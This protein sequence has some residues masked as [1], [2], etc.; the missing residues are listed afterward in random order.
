MISP[1]AAILLPLAPTPLQDTYPTTPPALELSAAAV[2]TSPQDGELFPW[3]EPGSQWAPIEIHTLIR[4]RA[5]ISDVSSEI[6][7]DGGRVRLDDARLSI[8]GGLVDAFE[9]QFTLDGGDAGSQPE[10]ELELLEGYGDFPIGERHSIR[11]GQFKQPFLRGALTPKASLT[12]FDRSAVALGANGYDLG[13]RADGHYELLDLTFALQNGG[14]DG[15]NESLATARA[16]LH[17]L[18]GGVPLT[19]SMFGDTG[20]ARLSFG[21]AFSDDSSIDRGSSWALDAAWRANNWQL[22]GE[23]VSNDEDVGDNNPFALTMTHMLFSE[24]WEF[25]ARFQDL[26]DVGGSQVYS[27]VLRRYFLRG[28]V[29]A[30]LQADYAD[31]NDV[32]VEG[33]RGLLGLTVNL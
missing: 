19:Q 27:L 22:L 12:F 2:V 13:V 28:R 26:D 14:D 4:A 8:N 33:T 32:E 6:S 5:E 15:G 7:N 24:E 29:S 30:H 11:F 25:G 31:S 3:Q 10:G 21:L 18:G 23:Y 17:P 20:E 1:L 9:F 16:E